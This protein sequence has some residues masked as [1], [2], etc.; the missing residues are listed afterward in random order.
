MA[1]VVQAKFYGKFFLSLATKQIHLDNDVIKAMLCP[2]SYTPDQDAHQFRSDVT[3]EITG[4]GYN[5]GG[6]VVD[7]NLAYDSSNNRLVIDGPDIAWDEATF[8]ARSLVL[9]DST[10]ATDAT[11]PLIG[12]LLF[13]QD[14]Q[15]TNSSFE[16]AWDGSGI[17]YVTAA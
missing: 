14:V 6:L 10:P 17:A 3:A 5:A 15:V 4:T 7:I 11:R 9:Y 12:Y 2:A 13:D 8:A 16:V 1:T